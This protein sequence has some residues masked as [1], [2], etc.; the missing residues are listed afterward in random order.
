MDELREYLIQLYE[1]SL[2]LNLES[3]YDI[4]EYSY[5]NVNDELHLV[6]IKPKCV[7][8]TTIHVLDIFDVIDSNATDN[9]EIKVL[10]L[11]S[12][13]KRIMDS[14]FT[15]QHLHE[16]Y[17]EDSNNKL[18]ICDRAFN[19]CWTLRTFECNHIYKISNYAFQNCYNLQSI[20]LD[21]VEYIGYGCFSGN[22]N[23][24][25]ISLTSIKVLKEGCFKG[26]TN[27]AYIYIGE[28]LEILKCNI[29]TCCISLVRVIFDSNCKV[30]SFYAFPQISFIL[31][32]KY[33]NEILSKATGYIPD[34]DIIDKSLLE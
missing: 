27:L 19:G 3:V 22:T 25:N 17:V 8:D 12:R 10:Y 26:C 32:L 20:N 30:F 1:R 14:A 11:G 29:F 7:D 5:D 28:D 6:S 13:V 21:T 18:E 24:K 2:A 4:Y 23:L 16:V 31:Y 34:I 33:Y 9:Y 15:Q